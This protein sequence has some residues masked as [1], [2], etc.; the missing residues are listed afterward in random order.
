MNFLKTVVVLFRRVRDKLLPV[1]HGVRR[2]LFAPRLPVN[3]DGKV[4]VHLGC[5]PINDPR[6]INVD[7]LYL[8]H[9]HHIQDVTRLDNFLDNSA[10][11]IYICHTLEHIS[12]RDL[13]EVLI[14]WRRVLKTGGVLRISVPDFDHMVSIY[15]KEGK[16][17]RSIVKPLMGGQN[18]KYN[19]HFSVFNKAYLEEILKNA[20]FIEVREWYPD[21]APYH[22]FKDWSSHL[23]PINGREYPLSLNLEAVK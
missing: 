7:L 6:W 20:G 3:K 12:Y 14:E 5:G 16:G 18:Y 23:Y 10:D 2:R 8:P 11:L 15:N 22:S 19:F 4:L 9:V 1:V 21:R 17:I 13:P